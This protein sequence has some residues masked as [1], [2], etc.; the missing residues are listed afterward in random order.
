F[1][2][3]CRSCIGPASSKTLF[4]LRFCPPGHFLNSLTVLQS[5]LS[6][7]TRLS[8]NVTS[9]RILPTW[10]LS[11]LI[12][13]TSAISIKV[14][15]IV[16]RR[17][18]VKKPLNVFLL[19]LICLG[20]WFTAEKIH[21]LLSPFSFHAEFPQVIV[22]VDFGE[23]LPAYSLSRSN[24]L[25]L[26]SDSEFNS[27]RSDAYR[28]LSLEPS[29][30]L[31]EIESNAL[32]AAAY[33]GKVDNVKHNSKKFQLKKYSAVLNEA[34]LIATERGHE[35]LV[36]LMAR[37]PTKRTFISARAITGGHWKIILR[38]MEQGF[39]LDL[40]KLIP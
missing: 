9:Y 34:A 16:L 12:D 27:M 38:L 21:E 7:T 20:G 4:G 37:E 15:E 40:K 39:E 3:G 28:I 11:Q 10:T 26:V 17:L 35:E 14:L 25:D 24:A 22:N 18:N 23:F 6:S 31:A 33:I 8:I 2:V 29:K 32:R 19:T 5:S 1:L 30:R 13:G 36:R